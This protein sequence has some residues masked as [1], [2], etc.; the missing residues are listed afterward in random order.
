MSSLSPV[1][2]DERSAVR[3]PVSVAVPGRVA[4]S[5]SPHGSGA[6]LAAL[7]EWPDI[8]TGQLCRCSCHPQLPSNDLHNFGF[9]CNCIRTRDQ[10]RDSVRELLNSIDEYWQSPEGLED[11]A[12]DNAAEEELQAWLAQQQDVV[13]AE[14]RQRTRGL[15]RTVAAGQ[16]LGRRGAHRDSASRA[17]SKN[18]R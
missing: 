15:D 9:A 11:R 18:A 16:D 12:A 14:L 5:R 2:D 7:T 1:T 3:M 4:N 17:D 13:V 6:V 10:R 8:E